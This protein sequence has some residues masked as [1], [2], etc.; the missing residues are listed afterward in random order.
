MK[1]PRQY[2]RWRHVDDDVSRDVVVDMEA[3]GGTQ[4]VQ[5]YYFLIVL[6]LGNEKI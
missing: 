5:Q 4:K 2:D 1:D 6:V 3:G